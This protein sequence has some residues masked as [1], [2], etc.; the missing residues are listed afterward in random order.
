MVTARA[1]EEGRL[2]GSVTAADIAEALS[3][4]TGVDV[5]RRDIHLD[6]PI[7]SV[8][9]HEVTVHLHAE[10]DPVITIDV[11]AQE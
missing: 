1:G 4:E 3:A 6:E 10:V 2:F 9:T 8:G 5:D 11:R 7:R